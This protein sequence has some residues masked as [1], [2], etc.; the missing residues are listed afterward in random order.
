MGGEGCGVGGPC[1]VCVCVSVH[2]W[3]SRHHYVQACAH[4]QAHTYECTHT[5][6]HSPRPSPEYARLKEERSK[7]LW[8]AVER[9]IPGAGG[10][11]RT[12]RG[13][14]CFCTCPTTSCCVL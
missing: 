9:V 11:A 5:R 6:T 2:T 10:C 3:P 12:P 13:G 1:G 14:W 7:M 8:A 4:A